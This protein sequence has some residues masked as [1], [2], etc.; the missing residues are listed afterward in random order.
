MNIEH[1][2]W[3]FFF[4]TMAQKL[5]ILDH[6]SLKNYSKWMPSVFWF[7]CHL[8]FSRLLDASPFG[9]PPKHTNAT[10]GC[11]TAGTDKAGTEGG[12]LAPGLDV[13]QHHR[14]VRAVE[15]A[16][17]HHGGGDAVRGG[18]RP[19]HPP[20]RRPATLAVGGPGP[21]QVG[22]GGVEGQRLFF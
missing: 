16:E 9:Q 1:S 6:R 15:R 7:G 10:F 5:F 3:L 21:G 20:A 8:F 2:F 18:V 22:W 14:G 4:G 12:A 13:G 11:H 19:P 17:R